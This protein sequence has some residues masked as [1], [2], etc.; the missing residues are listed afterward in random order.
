MKSFI[1]CLSVGLAITLFPMH[2]RAQNN[3]DPIEI[4]ADISLEWH[5]N[6]QKFIARQNAVAKQGDTSVKG[7]TLTA[8]YR[9][10]AQS[11]IDI[12]ELTAVNNVEVKNKT[13]TAYGDKAIYNVDA[14]IATLTGQNLRLVSLDQTITA[15]EKFTYN[16]GTLQATAIGNAV[17][18]RAGDTIQANT[19]KAIFKDDKTQP[20][21]NNQ[22]Q[23]IERMDAIGKVIITTP[24][25]VLTGD[26]AIYLSAS[27]TAE[28]TGNV[29]I[30]RGPN[31]LEGAKA[32]VD[33]N[34]N[35]SKMFGASETGERVR[36]V[37]FPKSREAET[38]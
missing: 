19:I 37:F 10:S 18:K 7:E 8:L 25:E 17:V 32:T 26:R 2:T 16:S 22:A 9:S 13:S 23:G 14:Q 5:R 12:Y 27:D 33:L 24:E 38:E 15:T 31:I 35:I 30:M 34:T 29:K 28:I 36:G 3:S 20:S 21:S 6:D 11:D 1:I 4:T